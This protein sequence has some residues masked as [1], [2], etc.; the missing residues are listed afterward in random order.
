LDLNAPLSE[1]LIQDETRLTAV[2]PTIQ[3]ILERT[4]KLVLASHLGRPK[5]QSNRAYSLEP[6]G[7]RLS[8][9]L[10]REILLVQDYAE[11]PIDQLLKQLG[12]NQVILLENL[13]FHEEETKENEGFAKNLMKGIDLYVNDAFGALHRPH[14][15]ICAAALQVPRENRAIGLLVEK[16]IEALQPLMTQV[17][18]PYTIVMGGA[19]V[20]DK[21]GVILHLLEHCNSL[22]IGG[23]MAY[24]FM[25]IQGVPIGNSF[26]EREKRAL[27]QSILDRAQ[28]RKVEICLPIDHICGQALEASTPHQVVEGRAIPAGWMGLDIGPQTIRLFERHIQSASTVFWNGPMGVFEWAPFSQ[29]TLKVAEALARCPGYTVV[30]GGDSVSAVNQARVA[31]QISHVSTGGGA[32]LA[33][34]E[35][36]LLPGLRVLQKKE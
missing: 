35:G 16:E 3:Y 26:V 2:L 20:E 5:G 31:R 19:K 18:H 11:E 30:G 21:M 36:D 6:I 33:F 10:G 17:R 1:G 13:R 9:L 8:E 24:T 22:L 28:A 29:G 25:E 7:K 32:S 34:L 23:A 27:C 15:S 4:H 14:S 12:K